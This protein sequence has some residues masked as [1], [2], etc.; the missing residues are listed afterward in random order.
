MQELVKLL[1]TS[2]DV[3]VKDSYGSSAL[4]F[5]AMRGNEVAT[6][7][8]LQVPGIDV[9]VCAI[10]ASILFSFSSEHIH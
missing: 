1:A 8:L 4:H 3:N 2:H 9:D 5:A 7:A 6:A 10:L